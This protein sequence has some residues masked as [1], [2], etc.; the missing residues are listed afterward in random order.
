MLTVTADTAG[1]HDTCAGCCSCE[2]NTV[3]FGEARATCMPAA[4]TSSSNSPAT[5]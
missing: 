4:R 3:R 5:A 1:R 2:S